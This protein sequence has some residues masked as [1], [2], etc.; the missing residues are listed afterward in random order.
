VTQ[1]VPFPFPIP[2]PKPTDIETD[3]EIAGAV[4]S[5]FEEK[6]RRFATNDEVRSLAF[7]CR[8]YGM[9]ETSQ[10]IAVARDKGCVSNLAYIHGIL[11]NRRTE[12]RSHA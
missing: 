11:K 3:L 8:K 6:V 12:G 2:C 7:F 9:D 5:Y 4:L 1:P 10:A